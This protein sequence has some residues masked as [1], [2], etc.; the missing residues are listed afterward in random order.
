MKEAFIAV[1]GLL[2]QS[3]V[4]FAAIFLFKLAIV[5]RSVLGRM[6]GKL[7]GATRGI[8]NSAKDFGESRNF[9]QRRQFARDAR[10][11]EQRRTNVADY[12]ERITGDNARSRLLRRRAA[13]GMTGQVMGSITNDRAG[14]N[15]A[16][17]QRQYAGGVAQRERLEHEE[18][19]QGS[20]LIEATRITSPSQ[21]A[22]LA[23]G[24][25]AT[26]IDG[27]TISAA[28]NRSLQLAAIQKIIKAQ[29]AE[30]IE[31][32]FMNRM[33]VTRDRTTGDVV[34]SE[35]GNV[36]MDMLVGELQKE[37]NYSTSKGAGAHFVQMQPRAYSQSEVR[38]AAVRGLSGLSADKLAT[39]D[40]PAWQSAARG[41]ADS[42]GTVDERRTIWDQVQAIHADP[43]AEN[44]IKGSARDAYLSILGSTRP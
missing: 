1:S 32:L 44:N 39:Q 37:Q 43:R 34:S 2:L 25:T 20:M 17:Q 6:A 4:G 30:Q 12:A 41:F 13:G 21:L 9:Y 42:Q 35:Q 28:N 8:T 24:G 15:Q 26:G 36:D 29:D 11:Q 18:V 38:A 33:N 10:K 40:G 5:S 19:Q 23:A 22:N 7:D 27:R 31:N 14:A 16:G 3:A